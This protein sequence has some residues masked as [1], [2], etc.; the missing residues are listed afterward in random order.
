MDDLRELLARLGLLRLRRRRMRSRR[1][2]VSSWSLVRTRW[3]TTK[4]T[5]AH[6]T[7]FVGKSLTAHGGQNPV[8]PIRAGKPVIFGPHMENFGRLAHS[9]VAAEGAIEISDEASLAS[10]AARLL[11]NADLR[12]LVAE[13]ARRVLDPHRRATQRTAD[14]LHVFARG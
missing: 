13:R 6:W 4:R 3:N 1:S 2:P 9:L 14:L 10:A 12:A 8:E 7:V 5:Q 11:R